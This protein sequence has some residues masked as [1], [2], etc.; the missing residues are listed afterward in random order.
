MFEFGIG[1]GAEKV[2]E[3]LARQNQGRYILSM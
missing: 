3:V 1:E 2:R